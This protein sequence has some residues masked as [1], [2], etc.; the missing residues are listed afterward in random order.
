M[1]PR[2]AHDPLRAVHAQRRDDE[3]QAAAAPA[4]WKTNA[5]AQVP[6]A[7][8]R[9]ATALIAKARNNAPTSVTPPNMDQETPAAPA[10]AHAETPGAATTAARAAALLMGAEGSHSST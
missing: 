4:I 9:P 8:Y 3:R 1:A 6:E 10:R 7:R 2:P 5:P